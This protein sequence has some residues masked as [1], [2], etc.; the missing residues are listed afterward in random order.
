MTLESPETYILNNVIEFMV[1]GL[2]SSLQKTRPSET[3]STLNTIRYD[4]ESKMGFLTSIN[5]LRTVYRDPSLFLFS[6]VMT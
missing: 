3:S 5:I 1:P 2:P 6:S 4:T